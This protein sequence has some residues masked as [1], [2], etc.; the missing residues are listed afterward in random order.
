MKITK[1]QKKVEVIVFSIKIS[2]VLM[3]CILFHFIVY[4]V[5]V[6]FAMNWH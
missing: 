5:F 6:L 4:I 3:N 1:N 2:G